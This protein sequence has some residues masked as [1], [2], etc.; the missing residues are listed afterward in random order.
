MTNRW[1][2]LLAAP[3]TVALAP[4]S[5]QEKPPSAP[6]SYY[7]PAALAAGIS[8]HVWLNCSW[9]AQS[10]PKDCQVVDEGP[11]GQGFGE[12]ALKM[13]ADAKPDTKVTV[14][15]LKDRRAYVTFTAS[16]PRIWPDEI[17]PMKVIT[18][19]DWLVRPTPQQ[20]ASFFPRGAKARTARVTLTCTVS[21]DTTV[22]DCRVRDETPAGQ[23]FGEAALKAS[24]LFRMSPKTVDGQP[25]DGGVINAGL[26]FS[27]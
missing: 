8:G 15:E 24:K 27:R 9:T 1:L 6:L 17:Q 13:A 26:V 25:E 22:R 23:G 5:A 2:L 7:P 16:P 4:A 3:A 19:P 18:R 14:P 21:I 20:M 10:Q 12:A 11:V